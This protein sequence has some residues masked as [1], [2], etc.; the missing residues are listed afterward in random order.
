[1]VRRGDGDDDV[2]HRVA[3]AVSVL[4]RF[5]LT[6]YHAR[7]Y[8]A[9]YRLRQATARQ[10][11]ETSGIPRERVYDAMNELHDRGLVD[12]QH[13][14][15]RQYRPITAEQ[16]LAKL[17]DERGKSIREARELLADLDERSDADPTDD[18]VWVVSNRQR[19]LELEQ[20]LVDEATEQVVFGAATQAVIDEETIECFREASAQVEVVIDGEDVD[21]LPTELVEADTI[22]VMNARQ[23]WE[24]TPELDGHVGRILVADRTSVLVSTLVDPEAESRAASEEYAVWSRGGGAGDGFVIA[25]AGLMLDRVD[26]RI[27]DD[28]E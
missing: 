23:P 27:L 9:A 8:V 3:E 25:F 18:G 2:E 17:D 22:E 16:L 11:A 19:V 12:V 4:T 28:A 10:I 1:M 6:T 14:T 7:A 21:A 24:K 20:Q 13:S 5:G 15:P 26:D